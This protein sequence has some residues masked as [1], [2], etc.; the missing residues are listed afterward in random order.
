[1]MK[2]SDALAPVSYTHLDV[3][4]RQAQG[5]AYHAARLGV[6]A[7]IVMPNGTPFTKVE[8][9]RRHGARVIIHGQSL[10]ELSL[11]HI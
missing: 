4:K 6:P 2:R 9:T 3:Y 10:V 1:M 11:I 5:V 8:H 7:T